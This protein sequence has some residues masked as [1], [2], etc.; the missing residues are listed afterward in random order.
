LGARFILA[1]VAATVATGVQFAWAANPLTLTPSS[2]Y[3]TDAFVADTY[4]AC[5]VGA[6]LPPPVTEYIYWDEG[7]PFTG[8]PLTIR[9]SVPCDSNTKPPSYHASFK[10]APPPNANKP[11]PH[12]VGF[13]WI[14]AQGQSFNYQTQYT[15]VPVPTPTPTPQ[16]TPT[17]TSTPKPTPTPTA[18]PTGTPVGVATATPT[19]AP[20]GP[21]TPEPS[22]SATS[23]PTPIGTATP[24]P[25]AGIGTPTP[26]PGTRTTNPPTSLLGKLTPPTVA[27]GALCILFPLALLG[28][29]FFMLGG[30]GVSVAGAAAAPSVVPTD[31]PPVDDGPPAPPDPPVESPP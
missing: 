11:G 24:G 7:K 16:P 29:A 3:P 17:P 8:T 23:T 9:Q 26:T 30:A 12:V 22:A 25:V 5:P 15:I 4:L 21:P 1:L 10:F 27:V 18:V 6:A 31:A 14:N 2:G 13:D 28:A 19:P 20:S